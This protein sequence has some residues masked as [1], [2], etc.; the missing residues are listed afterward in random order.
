MP[1]F[2]SL[3]NREVT[4]CLELLLIELND[5]FFFFFAS[6]FLLLLTFHIPARVV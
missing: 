4:V 6:G 3:S 1:P 2:P 5:F